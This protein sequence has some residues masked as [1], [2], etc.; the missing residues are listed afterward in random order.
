MANTNTNPSSASANMGWATV[1]Q[2]KKMLTSN[3]LDVTFTK[4]D[5][6]ERKMKCTLIPSRVPAAAAAKES[7]VNV[8]AYDL[9]KSAWRSI[10]V[11]A[12]KKV[13]VVS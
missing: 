10:P 8:V 13:S 6:S 7:T 4:Q 3:V 9:D 12:I 1:A 2:F 11:A 5:G